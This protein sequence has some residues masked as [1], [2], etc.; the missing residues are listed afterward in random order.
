MAEATDGSACYVLQWPHPSYESLW[1]ETVG[2]YARAGITLPVWRDTDPAEARPAW[3]HPWTMWMLRLELGLP[4]L[5]PEDP[6][7]WPNLAEAGDTEPVHECGESDAESIDR[8]DAS[9]F[10]TGRAWRDGRPT[11]W[12]RRIGAASAQDPPPQHPRNATPPRP[13][14]RK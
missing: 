7:E 10:P 13:R 8:D 1:N 5:H 9:E 3:C 14:R 4:S 11:P 12:P 2:I 6:E